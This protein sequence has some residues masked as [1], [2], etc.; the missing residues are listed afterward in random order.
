[1]LEEMRW[2]VDERM[3]GHPSAVRDGYYRISHRNIDRVWL[4]QEFGHFTSRQLHQAADAGLRGGQGDDSFLYTMDRLE[5]IEEENKSI[6]SKLPTKRT[7][8]EKETLTFHQ[9]HMKRLIQALGRE[10]P[11]M[12]TQV[13]LQAEQLMTTILDHVIC[14]LWR[15]ETD[16]DFVEWMLQMWGYTYNVRMSHSHLQIAILEKQGWVLE[17]LLRQ[18]TGKQVNFQSPLDGN[19]ALHYAAMS[20]DQSMMTRIS[21]AYCDSTIRN[22]R[23]QLAVEVVPINLNDVK[24]DFKR[25][26]NYFQRQESATVADLANNGAERRA[27]ALQKARYDSKM[28]QLREEE[29]QH[30]P[31]AEEIAR[32]EKAQRELLEMLEKE[33]AQEASRKGKKNGGGGASNGSSG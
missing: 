10:N 29:K 32:S 2:Q 3:C 18:D 28:K 19:T 26:V 25:H 7:E 8:I 5:E 1:M 20:G 24:Q 9:N 30:T 27:E 16:R 12:F 13:E 17:M 33:E 22:H 15:D 21:N 4:I 11:V 6:L 14:G 23:R 31:T